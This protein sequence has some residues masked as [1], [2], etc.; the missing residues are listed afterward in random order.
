MNRLS[1][2]FHTKTRFGGRGLRLYLVGILCLISLHSISAQEGPDLQLIEAKKIWDQGEHNAFTDLVR[3]QDSFY[4]VFREGEGHVCPEANIRIIRSKDGDSWESAGLLTLK[5]YDLRDPKIV[6]HPKEKQL[7]VL[8]GAAVR[9]ATKTATMQ[10]SFV[11]FS[12]DG[13]NW[14][15]I[16]WVADRDWWLWRVTWFRG[17]AYGVEYDASFESR[18]QRRY[19]TRLVRSKDG[20]QFETVVPQ[21]FQESG[22]TEATVRFDKDGTCYCLQR[23]DGK[24]TNTALIG[25]SKP[26]Y[27][28]W[29]W[30]DLGVYFGGPNFIQVTEGLW[31]AA[32][33]IMDDRGARTVICRLD[34]DKANLTPLLTLSSD[35]DTSYPG[36]VWYENRLWISYYS[37]HEGKTS[38]YLARVSVR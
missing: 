24:E 30:N 38:I 22:P 7:M 26:P 3:F 31:L 9:E 6:V 2:L 12:K 19:G 29:K 14:E 27:T 16:Q 34:P 35:G 25:I 8:G 18:T 23:R 5:G 13:N 15:P 17:R 21:L 11:S 28:E 36:M 10:Q 20:R 4:C 37:S 1:T 32:G 33:R